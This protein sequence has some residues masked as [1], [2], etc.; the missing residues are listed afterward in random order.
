MLTMGRVD[1]KINGKWGVICGDRWT[2]KNT[3]VVCRQSG[4]GYAAANYSTA[5]FGRT[6]KILLSGITCLGHE[7]SLDECL[8]HDN[9]TCSQTKRIAAVKCQESKHVILCLWFGLIPF[10]HSA[11]GDSQY[12]TIRKVQGNTSIVYDVLQFPQGQCFVCF[13]S[14]RY[15]YRLTTIHYNH[16]PYQIRPDE[17]ST[18]PKICMN[19]PL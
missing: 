1:V 13:I 19:F 18:A 15:A 3:M 6:G 7:S 9:L 11:R 5:H 12:F 4:L 2:M 8:R 16:P 14:R 17:I 10:R